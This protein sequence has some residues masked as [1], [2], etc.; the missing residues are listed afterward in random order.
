EP[1]GN[2]GIIN[3]ITH[4]NK[5]KGYNGSLNL[6]FTQGDKSRHNASLNA[7]VNT[8]DFNFFGSYNAN[9]GKNR[10]HGTV[11]NL[12]TRLDQY[13][14]V[15]DENQSHVFKVGFDWFISEKTALTLYT[16]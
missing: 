16:N 5:R 6:G 13:F 10:F 15:V 12:D 3:I 7:N 2:S 9:S 8:G 1:E 14:D 11:E 4:K